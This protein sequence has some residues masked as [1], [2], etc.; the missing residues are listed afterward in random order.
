MAGI[1]YEE[2]ASNE[3]RAGKASVSWLENHGG[4]C[5]SSSISPYSMHWVHYGLKRDR[6]PPIEAAMAKTGVEQLS[7]EYRP[8]KMLFSTAALKSPAKVLRP[9]VDRGYSILQ[10]KYSLIFTCVPNFGSTDIPCT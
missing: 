6:T 1:G 2:K 4:G 10:T 3:A 5:I 8:D 7:L 9:R